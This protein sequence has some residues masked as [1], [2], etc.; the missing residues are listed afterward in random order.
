MGPLRL[1]RSLVRDL[2]VASDTR[3]LNFV[4]TSPLEMGRRYG[5][6]RRDRRFPY[7]RAPTGRFL[8]GASMQNS[9]FFED[10]AK[11]CRDNAVRAARKDDREFWLNL[12]RRWEELLSR[13]DGSDDANVGAVH[14][15]RPART[16]YN[17]R[18]RV[19]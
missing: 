19:A 9:D 11:R 6:N 16:M 4:L 15:L 3:L 1:L 2:S 8:F 13:K 12:A 17:K 10:E 14:T 5:T 18:R 7:Y